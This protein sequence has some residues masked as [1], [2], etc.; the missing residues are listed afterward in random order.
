MVKISVIVPVYNAENTIEKLIKSILRQSLKEFELIIINDGSRDATEEICRKFEA[1]DKRI[2][3]ISQNNKGVGAARSLALTQVVGEYTL[4]LDSDDWIED[5]MF[6]EMYCE[7]INNNADIV[8]CDYTTYSSNGYSEYINHSHIKD[9]NDYI[10]KLL[11]HEI[12]GVLWNKL[13]KTE[14]YKVNNIGFYDNVN[15]WEDLLFTIKCIYFSKKIHHINKSFYNYRLNESGLVSSS[16]NLKRIEDQIFV[17]EEI[18]KF[19]F[20]KLEFNNSIIN[21][22]L[23]A[24]FSLLLKKIYYKPEL[25]NGFFD[26]SFFQ[27]LCSDVNLKIKILSVLAKFRL[28]SIISIIQKKY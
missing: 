4:H 22:K 10:F 28:F 14:L 9:K 2:T 26:L 25:W 19:F 5:N 23:H 12:W 21:A 3:L 18:E 27:I 6:E 15:M 24:K 20:D 16:R 11:N 7:A 1:M 8:Y 17:T 13:I